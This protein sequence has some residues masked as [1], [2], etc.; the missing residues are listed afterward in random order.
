MLDD[1][2]KFVGEDNIVAIM[3]YCEFLRD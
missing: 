3:I 2:M 1:D